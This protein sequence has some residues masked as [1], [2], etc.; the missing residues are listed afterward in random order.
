MVSVTV[1]DACA[2]AQTVTFVGSVTVIGILS[3][4]YGFPLGLELSRRMNGM[5]GQG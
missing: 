4:Q 1:N 2:P 3:Y 5:G